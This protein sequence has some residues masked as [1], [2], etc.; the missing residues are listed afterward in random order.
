MESSGALLQTFPDV[1][2]GRVLVLAAKIQISTLQIL[3]ETS[4]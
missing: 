2:V 1:V 4:P 3:L